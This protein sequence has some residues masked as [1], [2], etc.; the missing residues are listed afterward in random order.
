MVSAGEQPEKE[1]SITAQRRAAR[2]FLAIFIL[3]K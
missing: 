2:I 1:T 3:R